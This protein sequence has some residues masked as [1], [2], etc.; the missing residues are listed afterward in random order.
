MRAK[1]LR[2]GLPP[3]HPGELLREDVLPAIGRTKVEIARLLGVSR[4]TLYDILAERAPVTPSMALRLG[5]L[6]GNGPGL[7]LNLQR[8]YD[9]RK[10]EAEM[11]D[12]LAAIP[13]LNEAA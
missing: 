1:H 8:T 9:L 12:E 10:A 5:K 3:M 13:T 4:Q 11:G 6:C 7:W 2:R